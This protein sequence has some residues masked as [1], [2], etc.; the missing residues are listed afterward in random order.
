[1]SNAERSFA[2]TTRK[3]TQRRLRPAGL[4]R[5]VLHGSVSQGITTTH[6]RPPGD[7]V[8]GSRGTGRGIIIMMMIETVHDDDSRSDASSRV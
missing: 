5:P 4:D 7:L 3:T 8:R 1:M 2:V 6:G